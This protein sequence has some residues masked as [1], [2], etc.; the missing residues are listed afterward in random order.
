MKRNRNLAIQLFKKEKAEFVADACQLEGINFTVPEVQTLSAGMTVGNKTIEDQ[1]IALNQIKT[2]DFILESLK[3]GSIEINKKYSNKV[4]H[5]A[6]KEDALIWG[7]FRT[8]YVRIAG[9]EH[10][11]PESAQLDD[12]Y[13][14]M[15]NRFN[16]IKDG[17]EKAIFLFLHHAKNQFYYDNNKRQGRFMMNAYLLDHGVPAINIP[18]AKEN[19]FNHAMLRFYDS[20]KNDA[21]EM[22]AFMKSCL[23]PKIA[24]EFDIPVVSFEDYKNEHK[25]NDY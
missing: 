24:K 19:D 6:A 14:I 12:C 11:P 23:N 8:G 4:H 15:I 25:I 21:S 17:Y 9:S 16:K 7:E 10:E 18:K 3:S 20:D 22:I 5:L 2:W 1:Q 13:E